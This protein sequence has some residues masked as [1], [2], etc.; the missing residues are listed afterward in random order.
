MHIVDVN[1][2]ILAENSR[3]A[4]INREIFKKSSIFVTNFMSAPGAGKTTL[5]EET[6]KR[7]NSGYKISV[8]EG[9]LQTSLDAERITELNIPAYQITT[10]TVCH[11]DARMLHNALHEF[12]IEGFDL[13]FIENVGNLVCPADFD[14]GENLKVM[15]YSA[16]EGEDKPQK[17][18][19]MFHSVEAVIINKIDLVPYAGVDIEKLINNVK[20]INPTASIFP[21]SCKEG[22]GL[23]NW[24]EWLI[25]KIRRK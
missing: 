21:L 15:I 25:E 13:L 22:T 6:I 5:L 8:I 3:L 20:E 1:S 23:D 10:G 12:N 4:E 7:I 11:L 2:K 17:Y 14:L 18:P 24:I 16:V 19:V 9:D